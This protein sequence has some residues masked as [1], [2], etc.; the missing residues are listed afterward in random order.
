MKDFGTVTSAII[1][2]HHSTGTTPESIESH[3]RGNTT[4]SKHQR[5]SPR[6]PATKLPN[7]Q[8]K[9]QKQ[10]VQVKKPNKK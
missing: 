7:L 8:K 6:Q 2:N 4:M 9:M 5:Q 10:K 3:E 1:R